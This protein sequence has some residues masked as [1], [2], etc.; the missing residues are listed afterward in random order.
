MSDFSLSPKILKSIT[1]E[2]LDKIEKFS[3]FLNHARKNPD[4]E[5]YIA[6][7]ASKKAIDIIHKNAI[8]RNDAMVVGGAVQAFILEWKLERY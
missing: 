7:E 4:P 8:S 3:T 6:V 5:D 1:D 2:D